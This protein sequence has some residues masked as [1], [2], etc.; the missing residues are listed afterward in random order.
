MPSG[1][2][3]SPGSVLGSLLLGGLLPGLPLRLLAGLLLDASPVRLTRP[4]Q[5]QVS[6]SQTVHERQR[7]LRGETRELKADI[8]V[9]EPTDLQCLGELCLL[10][11]LQLGLFQLILLPSSHR[12]AGTTSAPMHHHHRPEA[13][14]YDPDATHPLLPVLLQRRAMHLHSSLQPGHR[15]LRI[16]WRLNITGQHQQTGLSARPPTHQALAQETW[17]RTVSP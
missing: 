6:T 8:V 15:L 2:A 9:G 12:H 17:E 3:S 5:N 13:C 4:P 10:L 11:D 14:G 1:S 16:R 7:Q